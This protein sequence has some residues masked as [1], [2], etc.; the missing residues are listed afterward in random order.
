MIHID[1][2]ALAEVVQALATIGVLVTAWVAVRQ[3]RV[4][5]TTDLF[6]R[7]NDPTARDHR[8]WVYHRCRELLD[9]DTVASWEKD[10]Q[11]LE[12][13]EAVCNSLDWA[14]LLAR[15]GLLNSQDA[16]D[17][18]GDSLIR[19][20]VVLRRWIEYTRDR[21]R[22]SREWLWNNFENLHNRAAQDPRFRSWIREGVPIYTPSA[23]VTIDYSTS[24]VRGVDPIA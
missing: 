18:Y 8:R 12:H 7:F 3:L 9:A 6:H 20:W 14:G 4:S 5:A 23:I 2:I 1:W 10:D 17:L 11:K 16:I 19:S 15:R 22:S 24:T 13:L 21:R